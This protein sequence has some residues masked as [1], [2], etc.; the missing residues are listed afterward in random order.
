MLPRVPQ[1]LADI[2]KSN[3]EP[4]IKWSSAV[5]TEKS[6]KSVLLK[7]I[8]ESDSDFLDSSGEHKTF[9]RI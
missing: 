3:S 2:G 8:E 7:P 1:K 6:E 4:L 9:R 5:K